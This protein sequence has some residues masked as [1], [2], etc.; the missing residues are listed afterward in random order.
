MTL[1]KAVLSFKE[2]YGQAMAVTAPLGSVVST[3]TAAI[4]YAGDSVVFTTLLSLLASALWIYNLTLYSKKLAS[5]GGFYTFNFSAWRSKKLS[6]LEAL[7][8]VF[9]YSMLN[10]VNAITTYLIVSIGLSIIGISIP[11]WVGAIVIAVSV[12]Y[13]SLISLTH[14]KKLMSYVITVSATAEAALLIGIFI[15]SLHGG[16]HYNYVIPKDVN[17]GNL[18]TAFVLTTVSISGAG[19]ATYLGEETKEPLKNVSRGMWLAL[20]IGGISMF[21]GTYALVAL[22]NGSLTSLANS[23]QPLLYEMMTYGPLF[24]L[25]AL[26][27]SINSLL[28]SNIGTTIG[29]SRVL[30]NLAREDAAPKIFLRTNKNG[31]PVIATIT[32][33]LITTVVTIG[34]VFTLGLVTAFTEVSAV[35]GI[36][37][38][39]GRLFDG[40]GVPVLYWRIRELSFISLMIPVAATGINLWGDI[41]SIISMDLNQ[42]IILGIILMITL[43]WYVKKARFGRPGR[44]V[45]NE[46]NEVMDVDEYLKRKVSAK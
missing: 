3:S 9:A 24:M 32:I 30:F 45:V 5:A 7:T 22:W 19:A 31:E 42:A 23:P 18:A 44:L 1:S 17:M 35:T 29:A 26:V 12:M 39:L 6:F 36:L 38:L 16:F 2:T 46:Q 43:V 11:L 10:A 13:P 21:L 25:I 20:L 4:V 27:L 28:S 33:A 40:I 37:W 8:E 41:T 34:S 14:I 15:L